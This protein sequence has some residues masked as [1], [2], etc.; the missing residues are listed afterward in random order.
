MFD[1]DKAAGRPPKLK[2][3]EEAGEPK[4]S[5]AGRK[6]GRRDNVLAID[7]PRKKKA[8][9]EAASRPESSPGGA[10]A[11]ELRKQEEACELF[12]YRVPDHSSST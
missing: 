3:N 4:S 11:E 2:K 10:E 1:G 9:P 7:S 8:I 6:P 5:P 12:H